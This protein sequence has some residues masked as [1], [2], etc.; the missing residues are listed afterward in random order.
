MAYYL[1]EDLSQYPS[2]LSKF[3]H[4][5]RTRALRTYRK[6]QWYHGIMAG[7][8]VNMRALEYS[9]ALVGL[10]TAIGSEAQSPV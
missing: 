5:V 6:H 1:T 8:T 2:G 7:Q 4:E 3:R 9:N 10:Q